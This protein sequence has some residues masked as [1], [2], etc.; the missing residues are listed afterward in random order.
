[1]KVL[2]AIEEELFV[3]ELTTFLSN[4]PWPEDTEFRVLNVAAPVKIGSFMSVLPGPLLEN[5]SRERVQSGEAMVAKAKEQILGLFKSAKVETEVREGL[6]KEEIIE[7]VTEM[8]AGLII[9]GSHRRSAVDMM[10]GNITQS[11]V[12]SAPCA[13][14]VIP[15]PKKVRATTEKDKPHVISS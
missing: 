3:K 6:P 5:I 11:V 12:S 7:C 10:V 14:V 13:V 9:M 1:M 2:I 15:L 8:S 4:Y